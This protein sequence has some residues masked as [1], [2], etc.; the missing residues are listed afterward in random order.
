MSQENYEVIKEAN[1]INLDNETLK[2]LKVGEEVAGEFVLIDD[3]PYLELPDGTY[4]STDGL[5]K[6]LDEADE[7]AP[8]M[9]KAEASVKSSNK[10]LIFALVG[11]AVGYGIAHYMG[12]NMK[13]KIL[14]TVGG[15]ALGFGVEYINARRK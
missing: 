5:A 2:T 9:I 7:I 3:K 4:V 8:D 11:G 12:R 10:K 14:F 6:K 1:V 15:I 13:Q